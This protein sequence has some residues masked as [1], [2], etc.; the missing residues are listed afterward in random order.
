MFCGDF[1]F[2]ELSNEKQRI[3]QEI[4]QKYR[5]VMSLTVTFPTDDPNDVAELLS[6]LSYQLN[7]LADELD[8]IKNEIDNRQVEEY[9]EE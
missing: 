3:E 4:V 2:T 7:S 1:T 5:E 6:D 8:D 9:E